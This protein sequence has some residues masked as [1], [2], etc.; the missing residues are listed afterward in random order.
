MSIS[1]CF[2]KLSE[3]WAKQSF[4]VPMLIGE[5]HLD[6]LEE[7]IGHEQSKPQI[8]WVPIGA[9]TITPISGPKAPTIKVLLDRQP[10]DQPP[11]NDK[12]GR[13]DFPDQAYSREEH[14]DGYVWAPTLE[15]CEEL[16]NH[17]VAFCRVA[18]T[19]YGFRPLTTRWS[20]G[21]PRSNATEPKSRRGTLCIL[22]FH[23]RVPFTFEPQPV[24]RDVALNL[25]PVL[26]TS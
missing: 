13:V 20:V 4:A 21:V 6:L 1:S 14:I 15:A 26:Q 7:Y 25:T 8:I 11:F 9:P 12:Q 22:R 17:F 19:A 23:V 5:E 24:V 16:T 10:G 18:A 3:N 2:K